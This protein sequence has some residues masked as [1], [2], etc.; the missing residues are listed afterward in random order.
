MKDVLIAFGKYLHDRGQNFEVVIIGGA[1]LLALGIIN[2]ATVDVD[3]LSPEIPA[4]IQAAAIT[5]SGKYSGNSSPL[6]KDWLNNGPR[7]LVA[8]LPSE[9]DKRL[10]MIY[11]GTGITVYTLCRA[12]LLLT[13][14]FAYCDRQ[15]D[16][17]DCIALAPTEQELS[18]S[19][20]WLRE[21]DGHPGWPDHVKASLEGLAEKLGYGFSI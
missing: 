8:D 13:K 10:Q 3:C 6:Q 15:Q 9:W 18:D 4:D 14:L 17:G 2:R 7:A 12:D 21:R 1:A 11:Q 5:F 19:Y 16:E 20:N